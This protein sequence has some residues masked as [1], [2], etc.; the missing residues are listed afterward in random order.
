MKWYRDEDPDRTYCELLRYFD[1]DNV[2]YRLDEIWVDGWTG[3][4][5][6]TPLVA[7][8]NLVMDGTDWET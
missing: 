8:A 1:L 7:P 6:I 3:Y 4:R 2:E 5:M